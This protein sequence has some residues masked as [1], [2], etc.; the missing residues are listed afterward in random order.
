MGGVDAA[1]PVSIGLRVGDASGSYPAMA[2]PRAIIFL[3][4]S[5]TDECLAGLCRPAFRARIEKNYY[6]WCFFSS[7]MYI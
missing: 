4:N 1:V 6:E 5:R 2:G 3:K 7:T